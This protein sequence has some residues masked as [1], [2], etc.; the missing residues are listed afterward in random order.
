MTQEEERGLRHGSFDYLPAELVL[1]REVILGPQDG[2]VSLQ[3]W[4]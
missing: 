2:V 4:K 1:E 3:K